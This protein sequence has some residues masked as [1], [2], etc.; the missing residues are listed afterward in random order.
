VV[1][2]TLVSCFAYFYT[3]KIEMTYSS[4]DSVV[5]NRLYGVIS[6]KIEI[7]ITTAEKASNLA[8]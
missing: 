4:E 1:S 5:F 6:H 7:F 8:I 2:F 3:L